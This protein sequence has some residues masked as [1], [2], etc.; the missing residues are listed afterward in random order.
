[1]HRLRRRAERAERIDD[2]TGSDRGVPGHVHLRDQL[3]VVA[4][5]DVRPDH[6][7]GPDLN[8]VADD[9]ARRNAGG[10]V[11]RE[12]HASTNIAPTSASATTSP[13]TLASPMYHHMLRRRA[14]FFMWYSTVSPGTT[15][16]RNLH[17]SMV[18]KYTAFTAVVPAVM[19]ITPAVCAIPSTISTPGNTGLPGKWPMNCGSLN[20]ACLMP[21]PDSS[22]GISITR[23][24]IRKG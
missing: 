18:M 14:F 3:A 13:F 24:T 5:R 11:D 6:A 7:I 2:T 23:S 9:G 22:P 10:G 21:I 20:V 19:H 1:M 12:H 17:L 8:P 16:L 15:G 4:D